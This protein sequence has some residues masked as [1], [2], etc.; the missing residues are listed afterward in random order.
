[1][2]VLEALKIESDIWNGDTGALSDLDLLRVTRLGDEL[3][4]AAEASNAANISIRETDAQF[5]RRILKRAS[6]LTPRSG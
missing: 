6:P 4:K 3:D 5:L 1:M 2:N